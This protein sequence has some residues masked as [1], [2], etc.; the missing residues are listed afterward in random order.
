MFC[1][2]FRAPREY[3]GCEDSAYGRTQST[4]V[5][6]VSYRALVERDKTTSI[7]LL[8][9]GGHGGIRRSPCP[10]ER[11]LRETRPRLFRF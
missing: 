2:V 4:T 1:S 5:E 7:P 9:D 3:E 8:V 10:A 6:S 11:W